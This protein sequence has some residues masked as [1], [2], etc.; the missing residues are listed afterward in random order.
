LPPQPHDRADDIYWRDEILQVM[1]WYR[2]EGFGE[3][4]GPND[5][6]RFLLIRRQDLRRHLERMVN[7]G[8]LN[9]VSESGENRYCFTPMGE[10][11]ARRRFL[12]E[13]EA[14]RK[15]GHYECNRLDCDCH[16]PDFIGVCKN[17][18]ESS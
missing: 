8:Y 18:E 15:P 9:P 17:L 11:E 12:E 7:E 2:G 3:C 14:L 10:E 1:F 5:L 16:A 4:L 6:Q 13:F